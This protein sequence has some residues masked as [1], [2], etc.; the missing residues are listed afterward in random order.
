MRMRDF[1]RSSGSRQA[2]GCVGRGGNDNARTSPGALFLA[3]MPSG[4]PGHGSRCSSRHV[5]AFKTI[6]LSLAPLGPDLIVARAWRRAQ[7]ATRNDRGLATPG[8]DAPAF[9]GA[10]AP[11]TPGD[12]D[13]KPAAAGLFKTNP[14]GKFPPRRIGD[15]QRP[16]PLDTNHPRPRAAWPQPPGPTPH[17]PRL[18]R[19]RGACSPAAS[20]ALGPRLSKARSANANTFSA[21]IAPGLAPPSRCF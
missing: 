10:P 9:P 7:R 12:R 2:E 13:E 1:H 20:L 15:M 17:N 14:F 11:P 21:S 16:S 3:G 6:A 8:C 4:E 5:A 19:G 18:R